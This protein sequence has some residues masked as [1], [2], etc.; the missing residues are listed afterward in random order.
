MVRTQTSVKSSLGGEKF[1]TTI[2]PKY[3][4]EELWLENKSLKGGRP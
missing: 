1:V 2:G 4:L 3:S